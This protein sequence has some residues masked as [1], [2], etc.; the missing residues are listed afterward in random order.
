MLQIFLEKHATDKKERWVSANLLFFRMHR[1][2]D[3]FFVGGFG[4]V[5][6]V[7]P[8]EYAAIKPDNI[9]MSSPLKTL[10][11]LTAGW[12]FASGVMRAM[13]IRLPQACMHAGRQAASFRHQQEPKGHCRAG[14][15]WLYSLVGAHG[16]PPTQGC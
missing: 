6:W 15:S 13:T 4:T 9:V 7:E 10:Q 16:W 11:V 12:L 1:I 5:Q 14:R 8:K 2:L 3:I